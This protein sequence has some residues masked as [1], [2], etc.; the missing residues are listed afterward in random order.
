MLVNM[1]DSLI[2]YLEINLELVKLDVK[3]MTA[4]LIVDVIKLTVV[5]FLMSMGVIFLSVSLGIW[6]GELTGSLIWGTGIVGL[7]YVSVASIFVAVRKKLRPLFEKV[8]EKYIPN[9]QKLIDELTD[10]EKIEH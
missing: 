9:N 8:V 4:K 7:L 10:D 6:L 3:E 5:G 2:K 1:F